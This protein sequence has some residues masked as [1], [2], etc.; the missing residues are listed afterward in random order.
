[1]YVEKTIVLYISYEL[2]LTTLRADMGND[3]NLSNILFI[4]STCVKISFYK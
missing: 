1:M 4:L 2:I 3:G